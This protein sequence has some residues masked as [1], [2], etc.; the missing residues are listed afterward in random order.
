MIDVPLG[1]NQQLREPEHE[2]LTLKPNASDDE[3]GQLVREAV[4]KMQDGQYGKKALLRFEQP[5]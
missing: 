1:N 4:A 2:I 3:V 5:S